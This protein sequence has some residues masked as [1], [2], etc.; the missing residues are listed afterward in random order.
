MLG[1]PGISRREPDEIESL[2]VSAE[3]YAADAV[4]QAGREGVAD[5]QAHIGLV[6]DQKR[7]DWSGRLSSPW[8]LREN[9]EWLDYC[10][11][12]GRHRGLPVP[13]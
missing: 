6:L 5:P 9:K 13:G 11:S 10:R 3:A 12:L 1:L 8:K 2:S 7:D 4:A